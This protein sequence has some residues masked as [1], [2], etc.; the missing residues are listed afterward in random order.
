MKQL[1][2]ELADIRAKLNRNL[3]QEKN[4]E[5]NPFSIGDRIVVAIF[6]QENTNKFLAKW[7]GP[8]TVS[9]IPNR[10]QVGYEEEGVS[11]LT[12]I[13]YVKIF[14]ENTLNAEIRVNTKEGGKRGAQLKLTLGFGG[15]RRIVKVRTREELAHR[16]HWFHGSVRVQV[17]GPPLELADELWPIVEEAWPY[18]VLPGKALRVHCGQ[19]TEKEG[20]SLVA[21]PSYKTIPWVGLRKGYTSTT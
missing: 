3:G 7:K 6:P 12:H 2:R 16:W 8:F 4:Q 17:V 14:H 20:S 15:E 19:W 18:G 9:R 13:S 11:R 5:E 10:F 1:K 21:L